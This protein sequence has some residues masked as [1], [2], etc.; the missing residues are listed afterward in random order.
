MFDYLERISLKFH[1]EEF[2]QTNIQL[3]Y[4]IKFFYIDLSQNDGLLHIHIAD[5]KLRSHNSSTYLKTISF[6]IKDLNFNH[7]LHNVNHTLTEF[8]QTRKQKN[9]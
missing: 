7:L 6:Q 1:I 8:E 3:P 5:L 2:L 9:K 4:R